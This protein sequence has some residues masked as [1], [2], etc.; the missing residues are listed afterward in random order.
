MKIWDISFFAPGTNKPHTVFYIYKFKRENKPKLELQ[1]IRY[2]NIKMNI[3]ISA[4]V[5]LFFIIVV[6]FWYT[7]LWSISNE[8]GGQ[9]SL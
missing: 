9:K 1:L 5:W 4:A 2:K 6:T 8:Q 3:P 7:Q